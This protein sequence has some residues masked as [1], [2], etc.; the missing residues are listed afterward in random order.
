[1]DSP[2]Q[3][4]LPPAVIISAC[5]LLCLAQFAHYTA[6]VARVRQFHRE[7][8]RAFARLRDADADE[9]P[10]LEELCQELERQADGVLGLA[11]LIRNALVF[12]VLAVIC[13]ILTSLVIGA[14]LVW[15]KVNGLAVSVFITGL[16]C[17]LAGM[18]F[19]LAEI[20][21]G[22]RLVQHEHRELEKRASMEVPALSGH[23]NTPE[24]KA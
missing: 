9:R 15:P 17:M 4:L 10:L 16:F 24:R 22:L 21:I 2:I 5:G 1:M 13:M 19:V 12:L 8:F 7:Y 3:Q 6:V 23:E 20:R 11:V 18:T 14:E